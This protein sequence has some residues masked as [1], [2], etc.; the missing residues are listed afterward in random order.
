MKL[1]T[2]STYGMRAM[3]AL[4]MGYGGGNL[5]VKEIA[6]RQGLPATYLEQLMVPLRKSGLVTAMRGA[7]GGYILARS[8]A[9]MT[10]GEIIEVL[11][12]PIH[13]TECPSGAG[14]CGQPEA[15]A[16]VELWT[17]ASEA[18]TRVFQQ[19]TL[20]DLV[21]RQRAKESASVL[22]YSI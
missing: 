17:E 20:A 22:N 10:V 5:M 21:E 18:L 2:R 14:C 4:A 19:V 3:L 11:E 7:R 15:C 1:S 8:P 6:E 13:L 9:T 16:L 12:G